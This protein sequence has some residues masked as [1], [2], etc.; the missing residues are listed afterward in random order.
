LKIYL[1]NYCGTRED[2]EE[3]KVEEKN[4]IREKEFEFGPR[5]GLD[6]FDGD[7]HG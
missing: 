5:A 4:A 7:H 6:L 2:G 3:A 1:K